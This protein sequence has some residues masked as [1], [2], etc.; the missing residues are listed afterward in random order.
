MPSEQCWHST[1]AFGTSLQIDSTGIVVGTCDCAS[2]SLSIVI[3]IWLS[4]HAARAEDDQPNQRSRR[5]KD[6]TRLPML[7]L[8]LDSAFA[9]QVTSAK[10][11]VLLLLQ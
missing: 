11:L 1:F 7:S 6:W 8:Q 3:T 9:P 4:V 2:H 5:R 10:E